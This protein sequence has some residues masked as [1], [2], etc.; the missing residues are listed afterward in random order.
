MILKLV[1][2]LDLGSNEAKYEGVF[3]ILR[4][5]FDLAERDNDTLCFFINDTSVLRDIVF[6]LPE[7]EDDRLVNYICAIVSIFAV[8]EQMA[9]EMVSTMGYLKLMSYLFTRFEH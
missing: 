4:I 6:Y 9:E 5:I 8:N 7:V 3:D 2:Q 1:K